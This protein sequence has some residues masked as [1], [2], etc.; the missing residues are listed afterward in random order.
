MELL[1]HR[2]SLESSNL[3]GMK[4]LVQWS[5]LPALGF[6]HPI[7]EDSYLHFSPKP[8]DCQDNSTEF[9]AQ[10]LGREEGGSEICS[11]FLQV[12]TVT[13]KLFDAENNES[14]GRHTFCS[15]C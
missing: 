1:Q 12:P 15:L 9:S 13:P 6:I 7:N 11:T 3:A 14:K 2:M 10:I 8:G 5:K 4:G